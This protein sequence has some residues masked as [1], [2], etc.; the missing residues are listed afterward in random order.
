MQRGKYCPSMSRGCGPQN[1]TQR[2]PVPASVSGWSLN[3]PKEV[4]EGTLLSSAASLG[5]PTAERLSSACSWG[6]GAS[7]ASEARP[8]RWVG[9]RRRGHGG[10]GGTPEAPARTW[11]LPE[12][13]RHTLIPLRA[14]IR[15]CPSSP[16]LSQRSLQFRYLSPLK[17]KK[18]QDKLVFQVVSRE[19]GLSHAGSESKFW[20]N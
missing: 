6:P 4:V 17:K 13:E 15:T 10:G 1:Q 7:S 12:V 5:L 14:P 11:S 16:Q 18:N 20:E 2:S 3:P 8:C 19:P 9:R